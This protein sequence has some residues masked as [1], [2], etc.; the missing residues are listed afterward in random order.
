MHYDANTG[1]YYYYDAESGRYQF[2]SRVE[3]P[4]AQAVEE[5]HP[6][7]GT[8]EKKSWKLKKGPK[9]SSKQDHKVG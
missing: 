4:A 8:D 1:I 9:K 2:H 6:D 7:K 5:S 3:L